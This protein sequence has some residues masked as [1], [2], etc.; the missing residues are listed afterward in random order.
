MTELIPYAVSLP[1]L[2]E[3]ES[4]TFQVDDIKNLCLEFEVYPTFGSKII[5]KGV[6]PPN[7]FENTASAR[8][9]GS[10]CVVPLLDPRL[11]CIGQI[12]FEFMTINPFSGLQFDIHSRI[13]TYWK[14]TQAIAGS[15]AGAQS[16]Q[17]HLVTESSL[18]GQYLW[19]PIQVSKDNVSFVAPTWRLPGSRIK[20]SIC[21]MDAEDVEVLMRDFR[22]PAEF[23]ASLSNVS[24]ANGAH[25]LLSTSYIRLSEFLRLLQS[26]IQVHLQIIQP[27]ASERQFLGIGVSS[28]LNAIIDSI[29]SDV[30]TH[31]EELK[32]QDKTSTRSIFFSSSNSTMCTALN[33]KQPNCKPFL[34]LSIHAH[35]L[36]D[37]VFLASNLGPVDIEAERPNE[38]SHKCSPHGLN[39]KDSDHRSKS[40]KAAVKFSKSNNLL[41][42]IID[43]GVAL[44]APA[45]ITTIK[46]SG[47]VLIT[48]G[49]ENAKKDNVETQTL[50][51][52]DGI[53]VSGVCNLLHGIDTQ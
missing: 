44:H 22:N 5:A 15:R 41:G 34:L 6:T 37:P 36:L 13:D 42:L 25:S 53:Q 38:K 10:T 29:L 11:Q 27:T 19:V 28:N 2:D 24:D 17:H 26:S 16:Q 33:W 35:F 43:A 31:A 9:N 7:L 48:H 23:S 30:F 46:Q 20:L 4:F 40:L 52:V 12:S 1:I 51:G 45:L 32:T 18:A 39:L 8:I 3:S 50:H 47:L 49:P 14:S 21:E